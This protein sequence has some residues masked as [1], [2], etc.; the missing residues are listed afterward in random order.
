[1][2]PRQNLMVVDD[3]RDWLPEW[4]GYRV[5]PA[6]DYLMR[7][8]YSHAGFRII[9][10]CR[11]E[12]PLSV[13]Y[14]VSLLAEARGHRCMPTA[15]ILQTLK[16]KRLHSDVF[17]EL[18]DSVQ[19]SLAR[20]VQKNFELS[21]YFGQNL[22]ERHSTLSRQ[23]FNLF[24][25]PLFT[26]RFIQ[27]NGGWTI[28]SI[29]SRSLGQV[30]PN[31]LFKVK[32]AMDAFLS[33][34][35]N[36]GRSRHSTGYDIAIL[37]NPNEAQAPSDKRALRQFVRAGQQL[38]CNVEFIT[39]TDYPR[40]LEFD[41]LFIRETT[42][43]VNHTY[44]FASKAQRE[45]MAVIDDPDSIRRCCNK[46]YLH[47]ILRKKR[48]PVPR[49]EIIHAKNAQAVAESLGF[50]MVVKLPD[51]A[52]SLGVFK[53]D[54]LG[55]LMGQLPALLKTTDLLI[56]QEFLPTDFDWRVGLIDGEPLFVCRYY[57]TTAH[58]QIYN[59]DPGAVEKEGGFDTLPVEKAPSRVIE[60]A[61][62]A[63]RMIGN[64]LYGVDLKQK[65]GEVYVIEINDNPNIDHGIEDR[66]L[67]N[68]LYIRVMQSFLRRIELNKHPLQSTSEKGNQAL[69]GS[70]EA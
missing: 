30:P 69:V 16:S 6:E 48:I 66:H 31:H 54:S 62:A 43:P 5:V 44:R 58:W 51:S 20:I 35:W 57:M 24:P 64:G 17:S 40:L 8:E 38:G 7:P 10:L 29:K 49:T 12:R 42:S 9:N 26:V 1:M 59:H 21:V 36:S 25:C 13:G 32:E 22:A 33:R 23:L 53:F 28:Q 27:S 19:K 34:R 67:G 2:K 37:H 46:I 63:S 14:H 18:E 39:R 60:T 47:E 55:E 3:S 4:T 11:T 56:A 41:G 52:F 45:G 61:T 70:K 15:R 50:P 68:H 65:E